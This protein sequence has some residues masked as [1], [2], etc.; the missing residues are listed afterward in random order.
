MANQADFK[1]RAPPHRRPHGNR[2]AQR[3]CWVESPAQRLRPKIEIQFIDENTEVRVSKGM[4]Q[5][6]IDHVCRHGDYAV[7]TPPY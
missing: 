1:D 6:P 7:P 5:S 4:T 2:T 3:P